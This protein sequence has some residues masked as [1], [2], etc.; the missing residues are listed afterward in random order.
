MVGFIYFFSKLF[1]YLWIE[2]GV[3]SSLNNKSA[4]PWYDFFYF[5]T[6]KICL[7]SLSCNKKNK[8][9]QR[10]NNSV[11][12][13]RRH[14]ET[15][16]IVDNNPPPFTTTTTFQTADDEAPL[17]KDGLQPQQHYRINCCSMASL[18]CLLPSPPLCASCVLTNQR[19]CL[20]LTLSHNNKSPSLSI[21][22]ANICHG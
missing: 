7:G 15:N 13:T 1:D 12:T 5:F 16:R 2:G 8:Y 22:N 11:T 19:L 21:R 14:S 18:C 3:D 17:F 4:G 6:P 20:P 10:R 9:L